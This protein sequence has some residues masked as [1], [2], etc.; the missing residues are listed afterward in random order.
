MFVPK[1]MSNNVTIIVS[2]PHQDKFYRSKLHQTYSYGTFTTEKEKALLATIIPYFNKEQTHFK[3]M[4]P[5]RK[6]YQF[7]EKLLN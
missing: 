1:R 3:R 5:T 2:L 7:Y 4:T 6:H